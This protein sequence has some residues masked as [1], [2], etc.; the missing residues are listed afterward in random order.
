MPGP[1]FHFWLCAKPKKRKT[2]VINIT[3]VFLKRFKCTDSNG[4]RV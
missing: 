4:L 3:A 2:A 1:F